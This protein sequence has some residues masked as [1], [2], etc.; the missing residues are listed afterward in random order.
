MSAKETMLHLVCG[1]IA[2]GKSTLVARLGERPGTL[3]VAEDHWLARLYPDEQTCL[4]DYVRNATRLRSAISPHLIDLLRAGMSVV[5]DF[6]ANTL[7]N[8]TWMRT[9]FETA[10]VEHTL[11]YLDVPDDVCKAR[12]R[13]RNARG[14]HD[15][16]VTDE[17][18]DLFTSY[19][20]EPRPEEGFNLIVYRSGA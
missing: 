8:R 16:T 7:A 14:E 20:V 6:P 12:L 11:H 19:F 4:A 17:Q 3:V 10:G 2:A 5:L 18:F 9:L 1:K 13:E 15:F